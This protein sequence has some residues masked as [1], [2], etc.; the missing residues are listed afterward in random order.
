M[1]KLDGKVCVITGCSAGIGKQVAIRFAEEGAKLAIC[2]W[3]EERLMMTKR[4]CEEKGAEVL[5]MFCNLSEH[6]DIVAFVDAIEAKFGRVDV[7][8]NNGISVKIGVPFMEQ[9]FEE[10]FELPLKTGF[11]P[12]WQLM[13]LCFKMMK[14]NGGSIINLGSS[15]QDG[16]IGFAGYGAVKGA[17]TSLTRTVAIEFGKYGIRVN[18]VYPAVLTDKMSG[19][20][21]SDFPDHVK[22]Y[23]AIGLSQNVF[24]RPG[25]PYKDLTPVFVFLASEDSHWITGQDICAEG[26]TSIHR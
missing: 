11:Y 7:L 21:D 9:T 15:T 19:E 1:G 17:I 12:T 6:S 2:D 4:I 5:A 3:S 8:V 24:G 18:N 23:F 13:Q 25:D 26:G 22:E 16:A 14:D 20:I 10:F